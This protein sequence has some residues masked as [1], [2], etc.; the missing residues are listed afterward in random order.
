MK[1]KDFDMVKALE[2][3]KQSSIPWLIGI[4][5][6]IITLYIVIF[7]GVAYLFKHLTDNINNQP[8]DNVT[9]P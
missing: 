5:V 7:G 4:I 1:E 8:T 3:N 2:R 6:G 9:F